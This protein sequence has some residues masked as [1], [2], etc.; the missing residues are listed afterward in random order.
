MRRG[1]SD[2]HLLLGLVL[3]L[4]VCMLFCACSGCLAAKTCW[5]SCWFVV[6]ALMFLQ[7]MP[8]LALLEH[9]MLLLCILQVLTTCL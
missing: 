5:Q 4:A 1:R 3:V 7:V 6:H 8:V 2:P 9:D